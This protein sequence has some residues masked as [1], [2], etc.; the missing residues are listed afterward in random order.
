M[1]FKRFA[2]PVALAVLLSGCASTQ[3]SPRQVGKSDPTALALV[4]SSQKA[5]GQA[6]F[7]QLRDVSV[8]YEGRWAA[9]G[10]RVQPVLSDTNFRRGSEERLLVQSRKM[11]QEHTGPAGKKFVV[12]EPVGV[13]V[14]YNGELSKDREIQRAAALVADAYQLFLLG[15]FYLENR[16][17]VTFSGTGK[18]E[19]VDG[20][21]CDQVLAV[22]RPG[23]GFADEDRVLLS[24]DRATKLL[25]RVRMTLNG[26]G[27]T[28]GAEVDVTFRDYRTIGGIVWATDFVERIRAPFDLPAHHWRMVGLD[29]NR[30]MRVGDL[31]LR[32][33]TGRALRPAAA[34][35]GGTN[36]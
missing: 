15:P 24:I 6:A 17:G 20:A 33:F 14:A 11:A 18:I 34:L 23:F 26:L 12:R 19:V 7:R 30:G 29:L 31:T 5:Q 22:L 9:L 35:S 10:P 16:P 2:F 28:Q 1:F 32:G 21:D 36:F 8:R 25:R 13:A 27:S 4:A 3:I